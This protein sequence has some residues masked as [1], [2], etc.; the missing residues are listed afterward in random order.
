VERFAPDGDLEVAL[1]W[2]NGGGGVQVLTVPADPVSETW[3]CRPLTGVTQKEELSAGDIDRDGDQDLLL[4]TVW[5]RND[6]GNW[7]PLTLHET[8]EEPDRNRLADINRDGRLDAVVGYETGSGMGTLAWYEQPADPETL[9]PEHAIAG[10]VHPM[11]L[12]VADMD[13]DGDVDVAAG[14]HNLSDP[15]SARLFVF[16]NLDGMGGDWDD[17]LVFTGDEHHDGA[18]LSDMDG[19]GDLDIISLGWSH[20][21]VLLYENL[22]ISPTP[23]VTET[24]TST[25]TDTVTPTPTNT[26]TDT[27]TP[28]PT[29]TPTDTPTPTVTETP[30]N[31]PTDTATPTVAA[32]PTRTPT[33]TATPGTSSPTV[34]TY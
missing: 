24:P 5:L 20:G 13:G 26:P 6:G 29:N 33:N 22:A 2:H 1:S 16:E 32:T 27:V 12:D 19:D 11:S 3:P 30:T 10:I 17:H 15:A 18:R 21:R 7:T 8:A 9:W 14:E 23:T 34:I 31:T 25:P 28:T 4:G